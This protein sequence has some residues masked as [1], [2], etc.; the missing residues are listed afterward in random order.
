MNANVIWLGI[1]PIV[2]FAILD[3]RTSKKSAVIAAAVSAAVEV[4]FS[5]FY[6]K[7][8]LDYLT[9]LAVVILAAS[10]VFS[11]KKDDTFYFKISGSIS[12][13]IFAVVMIVSALLL[14]KPLLTLMTEKYVGFDQ[15]AKTN[16]AINIE[17]IKTLLNKLSASLPF[18]IILHSAVAIY[19]AKKW[20]KWVW[21]FLRIS[22]PY[23]EMI[24]L[25]IYYS[26]T[27]K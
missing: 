11:L 3:S 12:W 27:M 19:A 14:D 16:P 22:N 15:L 4:L 13:I 20:N 21:L 10:V 25:T 26:A 8:G 23:I 9:L 7:G 17:V 18:F 24:G 5:L 1:L 2:L 6:S